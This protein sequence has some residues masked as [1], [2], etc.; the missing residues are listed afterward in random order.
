MNLQSRKRLV[1]SIAFSALL[2]LLLLILSFALSDKNMMTS[3]GRKSLPPS[4]EH[5][6]GTDWLGRDMLTRTVKGLRFSMLVGL[7]GSLLGVFIAVV[8]G[9]AAAVF[10]KKVDSMILWL[11]D[12]F[13]G[14]PHLVFLVLISIA[15]GGGTRGVII[16]TALTHWPALARLVRNEVYNIINMDYIKISENIGKSKMYV[17]FNHL[18]PAILPQL[19][20]G[21]L[22]LFPHVILHEASMTFLGFG[23]SAQ[24]SSI[25]IILSEAIKHIVLGNWWLAVFPGA[26]LVLLVK[27]FDGI[28]E[29]IRQLLDPQT[30]YT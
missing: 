11:T 8:F 26:T 4:V 12:L 13:I 25:G 1:A 30:S 18:I 2:I 7:T 6:F 27:S 20:V 21:F 3:V 23:L 22:L 5:L 19:M 24:S 17:V 16:G 9:V 29:S 28:G 14:M 15:V 10:G